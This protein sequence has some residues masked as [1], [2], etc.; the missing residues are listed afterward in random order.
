[1]IIIRDIVVLWRDVTQRARRFV[2][3]HRICVRNPTLRSDPTALWDYPFRRPDAIEVGENVTVGAYCE[4]V[5]YPTTRHSSIAGR[6]ILGHGAVLATGA[7][8]RAAGGTIRVGSASVIGQHTVVVAANHRI[9][10]GVP[11]LNTHWDE[12]RVGV[13]VGD[14]VWVAAN[15]TLLPGTTI[16]DNAMIAAG[17]VVRGDVPSNEIWGGV[18]ARRLKAVPSL[19]E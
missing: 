19:D 9:L 1:M 5:V 8:I 4:I 2:L 15:C 17:S 10:R 18:P 12:S 11:Y 3:R 7:N 14:N 6:L 13:V 16:G